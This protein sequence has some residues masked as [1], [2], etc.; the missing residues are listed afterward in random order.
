MN[1]DFDEHNN[2]SLKRFEKMLRTNAVYFFDSS[3]FERII[4]YYIDNGKTNLAKKAIVLGL[5]QHPNTTGLRLLQAEIFIFEENHTEALKLLNEVEAIEPANEEVYIQKALLLSNKEQ[6]NEAII[7]LKKALELSEEDNIDVLSLI[8]MEY[9]FLEDFERALLYF[10][11]C[12][13]IDVLD[14]TNLYNIVYCYDMLEQ[15]DN[16]INYLQQYIENEPYSEIAWHQ[17]GRQYYIIEDLNQALRAFD[18]AL[19]IDERFVGAYIEKAKTLEKLD[20]YTEAIENF[21][22]TTELEDPSAYAFLKIGKNFKKIFNREAA[23]EYFLK[24]NEQ[25]P[26]LDKP[27]LALAEL[28]FE[29]N[30]FHK[31]LFYINK[32]IEIDD[33]NKVFWK[34]YAQT[35]L[36]M[37]FFKEA[38]TAFRKCIE[39]G[40]NSLDTY[41]ELVDALYF[42]GDL[43]EAIKTLLEAEIYYH[44]HADIEFRKS[45]LYFLIKSNYLGEQYLIN[46]LTIEPNK[47]II[48]K[49]LFPTVHNSKLVRDIYIKFRGNR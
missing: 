39:L 10:K 43:N 21:L 11:N 48:F 37:S 4:K 45:G 27:L 26:F 6:H 46:A 47:Y 23:V 44:K 15:S 29:D 13:E 8:G 7:L 14:Y 19:L 16:A 22:I 2:P 5:E 24:A 34:L 36:K 28:Y 35:N 25:D 49:K 9:L 20:R 40:D 38:A 17:L 42:I 31:S 33:E 1:L 32:L 30:V 18:F 41:I 3:E 12:L